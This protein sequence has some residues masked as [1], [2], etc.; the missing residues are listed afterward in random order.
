MQDV[1]HVERVVQV[2]H[3]RLPSANSPNPSAANA[4]IDVRIVAIFLSRRERGLHRR[5]RG[6][7]VFDDLAEHV[8]LLELPAWRFLH[9]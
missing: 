6:V 8:V 4:A 5:L 9:R 7:L 2:Q 1:V 3:C